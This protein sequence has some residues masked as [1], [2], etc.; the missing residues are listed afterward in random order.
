L[1]TFA[2]ICFR[3][4]RQKWNFARAWLKVELADS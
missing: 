4:A 3:L 1:F 2:I